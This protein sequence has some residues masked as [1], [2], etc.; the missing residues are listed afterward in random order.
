MGASIHINGTTSSVVDTVFV[1]RSTGH[2]S[3]RSLVSTAEEI[4]RLVIDDVA[5]L[6]EGGLK[7]S[8]GDARCI[9]YGHLIRLAVWILRKEWHP[10]HSVEE[11]MRRVANAVQ[12]LGGVSEVE[13]HLPDDLLQ[14][15]NGKN[16]QIHE[17]ITA[18]SPDDELSF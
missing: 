18:Y 3:R 15:V 11:K 1:C 5:Q 8:R 6:R 9:A 17:T 4:A 14:R 12:S 13:Q 10:E 16:F 2:V 7:P